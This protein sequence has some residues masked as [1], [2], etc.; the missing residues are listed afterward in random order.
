MTRFTLAEG[1]QTRYRIVLSQ[2]ASDVEITV[3]RDLRRALKKLSGATFPI[4]RDNKRAVA[5]E[6]CVGKTNRK[7]FRFSGRNCGE[8]YRIA[9]VGKT[10]FLVG[11]EDRGTMYAVNSFLE[12]LG[13]RF[14][15]ADC[16][17]YPYRETLVYEH[18]R[19][20][21]FKPIV[22]FRDTNWWMTE[23][24]AWCERQK[25]NAQDHRKLPIAGGKGYFGWFVHT[26]GA[27]AEMTP[28]FMNKQPCLTDEKVFQTVLKNVKQR[29]VDFPGNNI[30]SVS[31]NDGTSADAVCRCDKCREIN[32]REGTLM[33]T[34]LYLAN[35]VAEA[36]AEEYPDVLVDTL[37]YNFTTVAPKYMMPRDN[38]VIRFVT[39]FCCIHHALEDAK[40]SPGAGSEHK[41]VTFNENLA[42]WQDMAK[43]LYMWYYT[44]SFSNCFTPLPNFEAFRK[45]MAYLT[46]NKVRGFFLQGNNQLSGEFDELRVY[47]AAK[48]L[49]E[50]QMSR[51]SYYRHMDEF[52]EGFYGKAAKHVRAYID[53]MM[54]TEPD[55][56]FHLYGDPMQI[57]PPRWIE[58]DG[59]VVLDTSFV[60]KGQRIWQ[61]ALD[62]VKGE[63]KYYDRVLKSSLQHLY[64]EISLRHATLESH[65]NPK[66]ELKAINALNRKFYRLML[67]FDALF[68]SEGRKA[69]EN[70]NLNNH[71]LQ[72]HMHD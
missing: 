31:Q 25:I 24:S 29:F 46:K 7:S 38:V 61:K 27:L 4:V 62:A 55:T 65:E 6:I 57:Y 63:K 69:G 15:T 45:D 2:N 37:S 41:S 56:H 5:Q 16:E 47:L 71:P 22:E 52:L 59:K 34:T 28:P 72:W 48:L 36:I 51:A 68:L 19:D 66:A 21:Y 67:R 44:T 3:A 20:I 42:R 53:L 12:L 9:S 33:G 10:L 8:F 54:K 14:F 40:P 1:G 23:S 17:V 70:P 50:P 18:R 35:R 26:M 39:A 30:I 58:K 11:G 49:W 32:E 64:Y 60:E 13:V 43:T